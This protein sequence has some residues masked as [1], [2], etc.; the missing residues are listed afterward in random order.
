MAN[1]WGDSERICISAW[2]QVFLVSK[3]DTG[4]FFA[5]KVMRKVSICHDQD[6]GV[7]NLN[8]TGTQLHKDTSP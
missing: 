3:R 6:N 2:N 5:M 8:K 4:E 1:L 7:P